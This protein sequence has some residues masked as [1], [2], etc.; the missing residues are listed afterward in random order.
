MPPTPRRAL[1][2]CGL[3]CAIAFSVHGAT[4]RGNV[5]EA[6]SRAPL[7]GMVVAAYD[8]AGALRGTATT[9]STG[10]YLL[11]ISTGDYR[12]LA[13][14]PAGIYATAFDGNAESFETS[15]VRTIPSAGAE[16]P[17]ALVKGGT[18]AGSVAR[19]DGVAH[20]GAVVE[21]YNLSGT[22]RA[23]TS[24]GA[25][26]AYSLV[27]PPGTYKLVAWD[28]ND[29]YATL[30]HRQVRSFDEA[31]PVAVTAGKKTENIFFTLEEA[32]HV[33][34][35]AVDGATQAP[36]ASIDV[37]AYTS[38]GHL[39]SRT[40]TDATGA[41]RLSLP[42]GA[43]R[44]V[45]A[46]PARRY[47]TAFHNGSRS[48]E[49]A[50]V[51]TFGAGEQRANVNIALVRGVIVSGR[52]NAAN[53][54]VAAYNVDGTLHNAAPSGAG[55]AYSLVV[56]PGEYRIGAFD[57]ALQWAT[58]FYPDTADF[59][60]AERL[61]ILSNVPGINLTLP[62]GG[63]ITGMV[64][65][66]DGKPFGG[67]FVAAYD[68]AGTAIT[69]AVSAANGSFAMVVAPGLY[70]VLA[71]DAALNCATS[72]AGGATSFEATVP[73]QV[74]ADAVATVAIDMRA[75]LR[76]TGQVRSESGAALTGIEVVALN[77]VGNR[78]AAAT[79]ADGA[80]TLVLVPGIYRFLAFDPAAH[81][82]AVVHPNAVTVTEA[83]IPSVSFTLERVER[84]RSAR[85]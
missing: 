70:R 11:S 57:S 79:S 32:A 49:R 55:G 24:A 45:A 68:S 41:Y 46:D 64:R 8:T 3:L 34:G 76:V 56:A 72:Y 4:V 18:V 65:W 42:A 13:Y 77:G 38:D 9:D 51:M 59:R 23:F 7:A 20:A 1:L 30:F 48:F 84:R 83:Q 29:K 2:A 43:Y 66:P 80:F 47:A 74:A 21:A 10:L 16:I 61:W 19:A 35:R 22:R 69:S 75:G 17:F 58:R 50:D 52:V 63:R 85:H 36:L 82:Y 12:L 53:V 54:S 60:A 62:R 33:T 14:D 39:V 28:P 40:S 31:T 81:Y 5:T 67:I 78:V 44:F 73:I 15:P 25:D 71:F 26:G 6:G 27:L 37:Y